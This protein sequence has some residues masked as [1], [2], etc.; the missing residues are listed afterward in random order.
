MT[1]AREP[2]DTPEPGTAQHLPPGRLRSFEDDDGP[3][4]GQLLAPRRPAAPEPAPAAPATGTTPERAAPGPSPDAV[5]EPVV[6]PEAP[7][8]AN[9]VRPTSVH[10]PTAVTA[11]VAAERERSGRSNGEI[12]IAALEATHARLGE[13]LGDG[14]PPAAGNLF[15]PRRATRSTRDLQGPLTPLSVRLLEADY[16]VLDALVAQHGAFSRGHLISAALTSY[17]HTD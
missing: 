6:Q 8:P 11:R 16:A 13:L 1:A 14:E 10:I 2:V 4:L 5:E 15:G 7:G 12:V 9:R 17:L 3:D